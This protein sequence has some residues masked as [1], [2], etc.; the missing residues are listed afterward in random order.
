MRRI[1]PIL[2]LL[3]ILF[4]TCSTQKGKILF[5]PD[6]AQSNLYGTSG[7]SETLRIIETQ[8]GPGETGIPEWVHG[9][10]GEGKLNNIESLSAYN[11]KYVFVGENRGTSLS[12]LQ[13]WA[14]N[15]AVAQDLPRL[16]VQRVEQRLI[17]GA[18][19]YPDDEYGEYFE[20]LI[21]RVSDGEYAG[22]VKE[23]T[24]WLKQEIQNTNADAE[25]SV[26]VFE[27]YEFLVLVSID[28]ELL[29]NQIQNMMEGVKPTVSPTRN[30]SAAINRIKLTFFEGF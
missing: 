20:L 3:T 15:F 2:F 6:P 21:K 8:N 30:Q 11:S 19:L 29:Q 17:D 13:R 5:V 12:N 10:Y 27:R 14:N 4:A 25:D 24:F 23:Q 18:S 9:Y 1:H 26:T 7:Q 28:K 22:A 16:I